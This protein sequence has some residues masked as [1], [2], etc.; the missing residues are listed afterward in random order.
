MTCATR[1]LFI[2]SKFLTTVSRNSV[3]LSS[4]LP[5]YDTLARIAGDFRELQLSK[6]FGSP[7]LHRA[8]QEV[9]LLLCMLA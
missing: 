8:T 9:L 4:S 3:E 6:I 1:S 2:L 7:G 5:V